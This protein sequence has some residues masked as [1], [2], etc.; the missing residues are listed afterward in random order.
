MI[1]QSSTELSRLLAEN[2]GLRARLE[3]AED[4][5]HA[6][7]DGEVDALVIATP[8]GPQVFTLQGLDAESNRLRGEMLA[9]VGDA[10]IAADDDQRVT[11]INAAAAKLYDVTMSQALGRP[12]AEVFTPLWPTPADEALAASTLEQTGHWRG[13]SRHVKRSGETIDVESSVKL[14]QAENGSP[15]GQLAVIRDITPRK[16]AE[17][18]LLDSRQHLETSLHEKELLLKEI[19]HRVKN[20]LLVV[21]CLLR[22]QS[23]TTEDPHAKAAMMDVRGRVISMALI[24]ESLYRSDN[25]A[26]VDI[27]AYVNS[28][29]SQLMRALV[30]ASGVIRL[31]LDLMPV[32]LEIDKAIPFGLLVNELVSN[33][34][35]HAF[36]NGRSGELRVELQS[37]AEAPGWRLRVADNG[38]GLPPDF[39]LQQTPSLGLKLVSDL[40][41]QLG[42]KLKIGSGPET[43]FEIEVREGDG[44]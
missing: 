11:F 36:P 19:H 8:A 37:L 30:T 42:G 41:R 17:E 10:V 18:S 12:L 7:R 14:L 38:I 15:L 31:R 9:Q 20:N 16:R 5:L 25:L 40:T 4:A 32:C 24:H 13:E 21:A 22:L 28:L 43:V 3:E 6:I 29:C 1:T 2:A 23:T 27:S 39:D 33:A 35:K 34:L 44:G 26:A